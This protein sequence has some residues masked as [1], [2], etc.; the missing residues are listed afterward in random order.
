M[1]NKKSTNIYVFHYKPEFINIHNNIYIK[2]WAGKNGYKNNSVIGDDTNDNISDK[3]CYYSELSGI[4]WV[5]RNTQQEIIGSCHYRRYF[6]A[7]PEP[8]LY[9]LKR[10]LYYPARIYKKRY[11][12]I[13]TNNIELFEPRIID[14]ET[15]TNILKKYDAI[16][17]QKRKFRYSVREHYKRYHNEN[18]LLIIEDI[19]REKHPDYLNAFYL[20]MKSN[21][22]Y[23]N[24]MF[25]L[26]QNIFN[27]FMEWWFDILFEFERRINL[28]DY[29]EYQQRIMGFM[30]ERL[31]TVWFFH[32]NLK[33]KELQLIYFKKLK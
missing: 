31:L 24:N 28:A 16:L 19:I 2:I 32:S 1:R 8:F 29:T 5:W 4:Y 6:T 20:V 33:I 18:D 30:G 11:G 7:L 17:P 25:I 13:Y 22:L 15:I 10:L 9:K 3:N 21:R 27:E 12:L 14:F 26:K 23:S